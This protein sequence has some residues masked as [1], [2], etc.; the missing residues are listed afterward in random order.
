MSSSMYKRWATDVKAESEGVEL[1]F[2]Q[3]VF[4]TVRSMDSPEVREFQAKLARKQRQ[5]ILANGG[6]LPPSIADKA[7]IQILA[8]AVVVAWRGVTDEE[9]NALPFSVENAVKVFTDLRE[10]RKEVLT[11]ASIGETFR[12]AELDAMRGNSQGLSVP[13]SPSGASSKK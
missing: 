13:G 7:E 12:K 8:N 2:G 1:D 9:G 3:D 11:L 4:V 6:I 10:F 5:S